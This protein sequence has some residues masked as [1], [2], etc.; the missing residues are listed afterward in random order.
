[1][2]CIWTKLN[3]IFIAP[4]YHKSSLGPWSVHTKNYRCIKGGWKVLRLAHH[5]LSPHTDLIHTLVQSPLLSLPHVHTQAQQLSVGIFHLQAV[6]GF[7][8]K[9]NFKQKISHS[10]IFS[11]FAVQSTYHCKQT[12]LDPFIIKYVRLSEA[13]P[14]TKVISW[15]IFGYFPGSLVCWTVL[16]D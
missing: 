5:P 9:A 2:K 15:F 3:S 8:F 16:G 14:A 11:V 6:S 1:M 4:I 12:F 7:V 13:S 10:F